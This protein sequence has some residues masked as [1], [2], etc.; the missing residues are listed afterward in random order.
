MLSCFH[1]RRITNDLRK[2]TYLNG[3]PTCRTTI[4][5][6]AI[7]ANNQSLFVRVRPPSS[8]SSRQSL[9]TVKM[10]RKK[11]SWES[12]NTSSPF[13]TLD[14]VYVYDP[15][16]YLQRFDCPTEEEH[17][18]PQNTQSSLFPPVVHDLSVSS[19]AFNYSNTSSKPVLDTA[20]P[21]IPLQQEN[22][23][24]GSSSV[25]SSKGYSTSPSIA[26]NFNGT[27]EP[28]HINLN[29]NVKK[30]TKDLRPPHDTFQSGADKQKKPRELSSTEMKKEIEKVSELYREKLREFQQRSLNDSSVAFEKKKRRK[31]FDKISL[32]CPVEGCPYK[33]SFR[34]VD[35]VKR[36]IREQHRE[37][38]NLFHCH[39]YHPN[40]EEWGCG[41][42]FKRL[43]QLHNHWKRPTTLRKCNVPTEKMSSL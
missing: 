6:S 39:G 3:S 1:S 24:S 41:R 7:P 20:P 28:F 27:D 33:G 8:C 15:W 11:D 23:H 9:T 16:G 31:R 32:S 19:P 14:C 21:T 30:A 29:Q 38:A 37:A 35:Y 10:K 17:I 40:G 2:K 12:K 36:H 22:G 4:E 34:T 5:G 26:P 25:Y 18:L 13:G 42:R 43:Y